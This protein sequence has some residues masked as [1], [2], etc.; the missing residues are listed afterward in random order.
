MPPTIADNLEVDA[1]APRQLNQLMRIVKMF[2]H[3]QKWKLVWRFVGLFMKS[4]EIGGLETGQV[5]I[6]D[7]VNLTDG[8]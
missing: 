4:V 1:E 7:P 6:I 5:D 8:C 2:K 3:T